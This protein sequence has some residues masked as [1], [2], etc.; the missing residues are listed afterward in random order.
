MTTKDRVHEENLLTV[1]PANTWVAIS[2]TTFLY[3][4]V[5][6]TDVS[7]HHPQLYPQSDHSQNSQYALRSFS[8]PTMV[9][10]SWNTE[11]IS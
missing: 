1:D 9:M 6:S 10:M 4:Q 5:M 8:R 11:G 2:S 3:T 7:R